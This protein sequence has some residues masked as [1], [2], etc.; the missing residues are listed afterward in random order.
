[1]TNFSFLFRISGVALALCLVGSE[2]GCGDDAEDVDSSDSA[3]MGSEGGS[4]GGHSDHDAGVE[5][6][7]G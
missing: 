3:V 5:E 6:D 2:A 4:G 1:M 7:A